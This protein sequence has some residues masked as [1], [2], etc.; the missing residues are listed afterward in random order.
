MGRFF[1]DP[2]FREEFARVPAALRHHHAYLG[3][4]LEHTAGVVTIC[5]TAL[6]HTPG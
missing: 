1:Q 3:G 5:Q 2:S 6:A 4:L